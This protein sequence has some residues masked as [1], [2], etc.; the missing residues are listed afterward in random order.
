M[1]PLDKK[2]V[3]HPFT[4][5]QTA[6]EPLHI[7]KSKGIYLHDNKGDK[8]I[9]CNSS[10]W[11]NIHGHNYPPLM[12]A[13]KK[14]IKEIDHII[15]ADATHTPAIHLA[16]S[17]CELLPN[18]FQKVFYSDNGSTCVEVAIKMALQYWS[19]IGKP[20]TEAVALK[21]AYH[22]DTFGAMS[23]GERNYFNKPFEPLFFDVHFLDFPTERNEKEILHD[24]EQKFSSGKIA[25]FI[26]EPLVQG[27]AGMR[28]YSTHF[29]NKLVLLAKKHQVLVIF[30]EVMTGWGRLGTWFALDQIKENPDFICLS[31]GLTGGIFPL[32]VTITTEKIYQ[33]FLSTETKHAFLHGHSYT[34]NPISCAVALKNIELLKKKKVWNQ[35]HSIETRLK[36]FVDKH[37]TN[38]QIKNIRSKGTILAFELNEFSDVDYF[39][40]NNQLYYQKLKEKKLFIRPLGN[41]I[42]INPPYCIKKKELDYI[43]G[44][45]ETIF[46]FNKYAFQ[47]DHL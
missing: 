21:G 30:D 38:V 2:Y 43:L 36:K 12:K 22:G 1:L 20:K 33:A 28:I 10:W 47:T 26:V 13:I 25:F 11:V 6:D 39:S 29:L 8:Y 44:T 27:A 15:F 7:L 31:K 37:K 5:H 40:K 17:I 4:Q 32:G 24:A 9:D 46:N 19:N 18:K 34:A 16:E 23:L 35:I 41:T 45:F 42:Y 14:Q 3:W